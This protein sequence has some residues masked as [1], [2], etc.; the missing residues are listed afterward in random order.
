MSPSQFLL[1]R[2]LLMPQ[3]SRAW[4]TDREAVIP[5]N[6]RSQIT[7]GVT[8]S[9]LE[10][11]HICAKTHDGFT[12]TDGCKRQKCVTPDRSTAL[13]GYEERLCVVEDRLPEAYG[14]CTELRKHTIRIIQF[15]EQE[16][17]PREV[18]VFQE[19]QGIWQTEK[20]DVRYRLWVDDEFV[21]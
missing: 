11:N 3:T 21:V 19:T 14:A 12:Y 10:A 2:L 15:L 18:L 16:I 8:C 6:D 7:F 17:E 5:L 9:G 13:P 20:E 1:L 4:W